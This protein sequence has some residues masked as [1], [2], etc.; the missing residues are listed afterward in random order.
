M[1]KLI[2]RCSVSILLFFWMTM[3]L[4]PRKSLAIDSIKAGESINGNTQILV[5]AQQKFVLGIFNPKDSKF[6]YLGIWYKNIPQTVVWVANRDKPL[7]NYSAKLTLK[8]QGLVLQ[9][10]SDGILWSSTSSTF[11]KDPIAQLLDNGNLVIRESGSENYVW[12]SFD[13]PSDTLLPGMKVG[14]DLI[15]GMNWKLTSWKSS[16]DPSS[17]DFTYGMDPG[18]LPQL[19]TRRG[20]VTTYRG[21]PWFGRRFSGTT[22]FRDTAIHSPRFN[23]SAEGAFFSYKSAEDL[24]VRYALSAEGKFEQFYWMDDVN[25][26]HL[27]YELPGDACDYYGLC[28]NFGICTSST[29]PRC[30]CMHGYQPKSPDD[31]NKRRWVGGCVIRDNQTCKN[32]EGFKRISNVKL[33]DS[34]GDLVNVNMSIHDCEAACLSNCSCLAY[35]IMELSTGGYGCITWFKKLVDIRILPD[36]GQDIYLRLAASELDSDNRKLVVVLCLSVASLISFLIFVAC[37]IFWRRRTIKGKYFFKK[38]ILKSILRTVSIFLLVFTSYLQIL[39]E[40]G[41]EVQS[42]ENEAE[43]PLYDFTMLV[44]ATNDFSLSNKIG[45]GGF[46]PVY[47]GMLPCGQEI[48]VKRQAEG[49]SQGQTELRNE[50]LLISKLQHRNLV[51]LLGF[52]IHQQETLLVYE[53]MPNKSLDYFLFDNKKR[54]LLKWKKR[55]D[56]IIGI[57]RG[58]LYLHRDSRL[59]IIHRDLKVSNILLDNDMNPKISDFGMAR[60]F[61]EDQTMTRTKRVVGTYGYMSPEYVIDGYFSMKSDIFSFGVILLEIVSGRKNRGFFH[62]DHQLN[63]LGHAWKLWDEGNG[64]ELMDETLKDQFQKCEAIR[65]IQVGLLC[66]QENPDERPA[67]WSVLS[68]LESENMVLSQP[69]Q[70]GFYTERMVSNMHKLAVGNSCT[71]NEVTLTLLDGPMAKLISIVLFFW[72]TI[73]LFPRKSLA[74]DSIKAGESMSGSAQILVS[75]QQKFVLGI[76][77]PEGSKFKYLGIWY[78][79]IPQMTIVWVANR[80]NP[81]VSSSAKLTFNEEGNIILMDETDGVLWSSTSSVY[82]K[83]P[84]VQLLDNGNLVL[85][86]SES[87]NYVWQS[88]DYVTDTLLPGMKLGRDSKAG[89]NWKLTSWKS[90]ND[91]SSGDFTYVMDPGGL[92]QLEIHRGNF[93]TYRSG[94]YLGS[95]FSGGYYL[96]ETAIITPRFVYNANEAFYS[97]ESA[98]NLAVRYTLNAEGYFNLFHWNDDG[99]YWQSLFKSPGD[100][101][102]DYGHCGNF[103]ICTFSVIAICDCIPGFQPKSPDDWEKQGSSGG[104]VRRDNKT[105]KNGEGFKRI[106]NVKLPDSSAKNLVKLNTSIQDCK[107][108]CLSD[109]SC[110]AYGRMEFSTGENGCITWFER[111]VDMKILPQNGQDIYVRLAA[112][113]LESSKR[114]LIVGLSVSVA[115]LI[116]FLIFVA[117]F[118]YWRRRRA[119]DVSI[120]TKYTFH[121]IDPDLIVCFLS[122]NLVEPGN[123][124]EAQDDE[125]ELPLYDFTKIETATNNFSLSNKI[126]EGGFGPVYKG[127]LPCGQEI[128]V[129][130]LAEDSSQGQTELRNEV[131]LISKLQHRNLVKLLGF[132]IHQQET[133]LVYEY[134]PNK[135]LDYFLFDDKKRS[136]LSW[137]KR[138]DII[139]GIARG[140]LYLH[141]DSRLIIIHRDLK[142]SNILLDNEMNP[143]ISDFGLARMF[144]EDQTMTRTKRVVGTYG[145]MSPE[146]VIDGYFSMKSDIF[147][148]GV[149]LLEI[150]SG[151]KNRGFFHPDH[152]LNLLGHDHQAWKLWDEGNALELMDETLKDQFQNSEA[153]RCIQVGLLCVQENPNERP[154]MWSVLSM[155]ESEN[156]ALSLPKQPGFYT[157]R[158]ISKTHNLPDEASCSTNEVTVTLLDGR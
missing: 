122:P 42:Q 144:G 44:N 118:I 66:V 49:S 138:M 153:Q 69:K 123:E 37:F 141:R 86:E 68:M 98:K 62:P 85:G 36:N 142:V 19:E 43:M 148:F 87:G 9:N 63:L 33:P 67:M 35:G 64:L 132:C 32:G 58:L 76:F 124:V 29:I 28:G 21:G 137:K 57:A 13:Y 128:A 12:Q 59:I 41:N 151:K 24:T 18:G 45:E 92:P 113:E 31:W 53:Y 46:G 78:K 51:K 15:T 126:G 133:L 3:A 158:I 47:K 107:A 84:V 56:I 27:L 150:I 34:S 102:D 74:V 121:M 1:G 140:L 131:L 95:R 55:L 83:E 89:M 48:A 88:F 125:V 105:C 149:I 50:V 90:R 14:W 10:E 114:K 101:C 136:L 155:L 73:A 91:P 146:Y 135:S 117:C 38:K 4:F 157:E 93:T 156:M 147:S 152:Q 145:Y 2:W 134:M 130:R 70:P 7:V 103:G 94:P 96:R 39:V 112:S 82:V 154:T 75:A 108:A 23:Y 139:I 17:G 106:S 11:L 110:L 60:M 52:C 116:S 115:S 25:D 65:C 120:H 20:N 80:D 6:R 54:S 40:T 26:W 143:R 8:G 109:C 72:T 119:E 30:D 61:G 129:K 71:S 100:A 81:F 99:N 77:N 5:S 16:N 79:N 104:C 97:Y 111:L 127:M 22:L